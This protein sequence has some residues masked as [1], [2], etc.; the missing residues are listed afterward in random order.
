VNFTGTLLHF[1]MFGALPA[2]DSLGR[3]VWAYGKR[4]HDYCERRPHFDASEFVEEWGDNG[5]LKGWCLYKKGCKGPY[6]YANCPKVRFNDGISWPVMAGHGCI[7]CTEP[8]FWDTM[9]P[10]EKPLPDKTYGGGE[11]TVDNIGI[12]LTGVAV[13]GMAAHAVASG[14]R[15][16]GGKKI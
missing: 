2:L 15:H 12:A 8:G 13:A 6:T 4:I 9:A 1:L 3:P 10:L 16:S 7:G 11:K 5:A 14:V